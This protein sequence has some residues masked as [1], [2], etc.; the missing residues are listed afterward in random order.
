MAASGTNTSG[1]LDLYVL[2]H[3]TEYNRIVQDS[4]TKCLVGER[5]YY[6]LLVLGI[7]CAGGY[8]EQTR[9]VMFPMFR[10][11]P[12]QDKHLA[13]CFRTLGFRAVE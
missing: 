4:Q 8:V 3:N 7:N 11:V 12:E 6:L 2:H 9:P 10:L 5:L 13:S 1:W